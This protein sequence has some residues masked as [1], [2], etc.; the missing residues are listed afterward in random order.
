M[1]SGWAKGTRAGASAGAQN[2]RPA[3]RRG[4]DG[5]ACRW[6][7]RAGGPSTAPRGASVRTG[8]AGRAGRGPAG[9]GRASAVPTGDAASG[10]IGTRTGLSRLQGCG[11][12]TL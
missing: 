8:R 11:R 12:C 7:K 6:A 5:L 1:G 2:A 9:E 4:R 10:R 3:P